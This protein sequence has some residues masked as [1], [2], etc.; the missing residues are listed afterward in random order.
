MND[1]NRG[2]SALQNDYTQ[3]YA[4]QEQYWRRQAGMA[5]LDVGYQPGQL[6]YAFPELAKAD[7]QAAQYDA[8]YGQRD[9]ERLMRSPMVFSVMWM[10][11]VGPVMIAAFTVFWFLSS[12]MFSYSWFFSLPFIALMWG[13]F[14]WFGWVFYWRLPITAMIIHRG[15]GGPLASHFDFSDKWRR[16]WGSDQRWAQKYG[17]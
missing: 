6:G 17:A 12:A 9:R 8:L 3:A 16:R 15:R 5:P 11:I 2:Y 13:F 7:F 4:A 1:F 10:I 14:V